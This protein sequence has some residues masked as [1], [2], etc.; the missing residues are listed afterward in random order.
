M[1]SGRKAEPWR[2][3]LD[4]KHKL[5]AILFGLFFG[6]VAY[7]GKL[8]LGHGEVPRLPFLGLLGFERSPN[9]GVSGV[10]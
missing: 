8:R 10:I 9:Q 6:L 3:A 4:L 7:F 2:T 5:N 1:E